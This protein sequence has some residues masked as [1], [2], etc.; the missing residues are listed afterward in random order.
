[1]RMKCELRRDGSPPD[2]SSSTLRS[3]F[4][5]GNGIEE[6]DVAAALIKE[7]QQV[8]ASTGLPCSRYTAMSTLRSM[9][10]E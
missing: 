7:V 10:L 1:M 9:R 2:G 8:L 4:Q 5:G 3:E 6:T